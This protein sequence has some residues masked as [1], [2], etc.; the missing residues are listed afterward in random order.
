MWRDYQVN[1]PVHMHR[2]TGGI[3]RCA[4]VLLINGM[5]MEIS[6]MNLVEY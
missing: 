6:K 2:Q 3:W 5:L 1:R 4:R